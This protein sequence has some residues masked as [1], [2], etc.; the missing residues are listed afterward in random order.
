[1]SERHRKE[2]D[3]CGRQL[4][5]LHAQVEPLKRQANEL[6]AHVDSHREEIRIVST[7]LYQYRACCIAIGLYHVSCD[8]MLAGCWKD[9]PFMHMI[10]APF[11]WPYQLWCAADRRRMTDTSLEMF[12][13]AD[14]GVCSL[15]V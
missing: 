8:S 3:S 9:L 1:M 13:C 10:V 2:A 15:S 6:Q 5:E 7:P 12:A 4:K 11:C 14:L